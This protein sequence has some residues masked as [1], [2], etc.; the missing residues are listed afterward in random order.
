MGE[1]E[2]TS[3]AIE[4]LIE[5]HML[6]CKE[7][8]SLLSSLQFAQEDGWLSSFYS[9]LIKKYDKANVVEEKFNQLEKEDISINQSN[10][11]LTC[12]LKSNTDLLAC[13]AEYCLIQIQKGVYKT[14]KTC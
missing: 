3:M 7:E 14:M 5:N 8:K 10:Q 1:K 6:T 2:N 13:K 12:T 11:S 9:C 4:C